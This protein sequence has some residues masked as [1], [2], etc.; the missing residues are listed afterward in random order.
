MC[1]Y[2]TLALILLYMK[3]V[4]KTLGISNVLINFYYS[5][6]QVNMQNK[7]VSS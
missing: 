2:Y 7:W 1:S 4:L 6:L 3:N 5:I